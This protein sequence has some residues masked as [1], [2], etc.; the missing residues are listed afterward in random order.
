MTL[1]LELV[2]SVLNNGKRSRLFMIVIR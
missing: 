2:I 1:S